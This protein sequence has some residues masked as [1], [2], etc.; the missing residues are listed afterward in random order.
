[1]KPN[2]K[3]MNW[4]GMAAVTAIGATVMVLAAQILAKPTAP[5]VAGAV[6]RGRRTTL[7]AVPSAPANAAKAAAPGV[8][9][10]SNETGEGRPRLAA[11][12]PIRELFRP[13][14]TKTDDKKGAR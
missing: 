4:R 8:V 3:T 5:P 1:M 11:D 9:L 2:A 12:P 13:L 6:A 7:R 14:V 10:A